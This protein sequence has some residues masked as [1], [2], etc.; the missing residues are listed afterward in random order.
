M[1][2]MKLF[3]REKY[4]NTI[5]P[6]YHSDM[7]KVITGIRRCGKSCIMKMI[8]D[9][10]KDFG[11]KENHIIYLPLD[12]R[13]FKHINT[14]EELE[15]AIESYIIDDEFHYVLI[16]EVQNVKNFE[17]VIQA[18]QEEENFSIFLT[19]SNSYLLSDE[20][21]TKLTGR[22]INF[23][24]Y[25]LDF[26]EYIEMKEFLK[27]E[28]N[29]NIME[30]FQMFITYGGFPK[31]LE[32]DNLEAKQLYTKS[33]IEEIFEKDIRT[34]NKIRNKSVFEAVRSYI[35]NNYGATFSLNNVY[36]Y[37]RNK[38][39]INITKITLRN[40]IDILLKAKI[41]YQC[42]RF[43]QK[44]KRI[45]KG[46]Y[47]F[48][49]ADM[50]LFFSL[51]TDNRI[52]YDSSLENIV[53]LYLISNG[54]KVSVGKIGKVECDFITRDTKNDYAYIQVSQTVTNKETE[55]RE[56]RPFTY[57][58]D[59][60]P[61]YLLTMDQLRN[62]KDGVKHYNCIDVFLGKEKI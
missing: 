10:L 27:M 21:S 4:L 15:K 20:I 14:P 38:E 58:R 48:Y 41:I 2:Q 57:L 12:H 32:F 31:A 59:G 60:Y 28:I 26:K 24:I 36:G 16:D 50:A 34:R 30:E 51:N 46:E 40:Y 25:T 19:G 33:I 43:D 6:F 61:R 35:I 62:S 5:R 47:K 42:D 45:L 3:K 37:F 44:S 52:N 22:Y 8:I 39:N 29:S 18:F 9:E 56:Y 13:K 1:I 53:Y 17:K 55:E 7:I 54:Y 49:I 11:I 23:E